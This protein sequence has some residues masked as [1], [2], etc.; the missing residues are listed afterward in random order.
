MNTPGSPP[1]IEITVDD[2]RRLIIRCLRR[3]GLTEDESAIVCRVLLYAE[4]RG[5][6]QGILKILEKTVLPA[7]DRTPLEIVALS[8]AMH[9]LEGNGNPGMVVMTAAADVTRSAAL[10][11]GL[12]LT[13][14]RGTSSST[15]S[16]G[17][18]ASRIA[19]AGLIAMVL[20]GS[21]KVMAVNGAVEPSLG[22]NP[23]ALAVPTSH[24]P[25]LLDMATSMTTWFALI[26]NARTGAPLPTGVAIDRFGTV[27][28]DAHEAMQGALLPFAGAKGSGLAF[29]F[30]LLTGPL[31]GAGIVGD[32]GDNRGNCLLAINPTV[33]APDFVP[34]CDELLKRIRQQKRVDESQPIRLPGDAS[35]SRVAQAEKRGTVRIR[36]DWHGELLNLASS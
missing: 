29:M 1:L 24:G 22:T 20:A 28:T 15:G 30:E 16:I 10:K 26:D 14:T 23:I 31:A 8:D 2:L 25:V 5:K 34:R 17:F 36:K 21:P 11:S 19:E 35:S 13:V 12:A 33:L 6:S 27:T 4:L 7:S 18:Y 32:Q 9:R 3:L